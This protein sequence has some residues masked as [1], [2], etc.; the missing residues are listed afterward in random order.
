MTSGATSLRTKRASERRE[1][2]RKRVVLVVE[3]DKPI[4]DVVVAALNDEAG[5]TAVRVGSAA[6][7][8]ETLESIPADL[9]VLDLQLPGMSGVELYDRLRQDPRHCHV[10][11]IF[12]TATMREHADE[13]RSRGIAMYVKKPFDLNDLVGYVKR[14]APPFPLGP[15]A[16]VGA[17]SRR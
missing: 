8:L 11:V 3:D 14:L 16:L 5:Y 7:A 6:A 12:E 10:P 2:H 1:H 15:P 13:L 17:A 4:G 9:I